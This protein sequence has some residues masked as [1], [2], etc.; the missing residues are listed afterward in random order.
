MKIIASVNEDIRSSQL[1]CAYIAGRAADA[2]PL[3]KSEGFIQ[4]FPEPQ[5]AIARFPLLSI[6]ICR[7]LQLLCNSSLPKAVK[8]GGV[9][10][11]SSPRESTSTCM[12]SAFWPT[13]LKN[14]LVIAFSSP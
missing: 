9:M 12:I 6:A 7:T 11:S 14:R 1:L 2:T 13:A 4:G 5:L 3:Q 8:T 10:R